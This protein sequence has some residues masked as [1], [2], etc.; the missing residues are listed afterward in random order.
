VAWTGS[1]FYAAKKANSLALYQL[2]WSLP[3]GVAPV[4]TISFTSMMGDAAPVIVG[5][6]VT[7]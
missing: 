2:N 1:N 3:E 4:K 6:S 7:P 5:L